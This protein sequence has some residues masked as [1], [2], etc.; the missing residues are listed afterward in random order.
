MDK[1]EGPPSKGAETS[2]QREGRTPSNGRGISLQRGEFHPSV[3]TCLPIVEKLHLVIRWNPVLKLDLD[4]CDTARVRARLELHLLT[5]AIHGSRNDLKHCQQF[6]RT[7]FSE[8]YGFTI[9]T[10]SQLQVCQISTT[11][12]H[13]KKLRRLPELQAVI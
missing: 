9:V 6:V 2:L 12:L 3:C 5:T 7:K 1:R 4:V 8:T 13:C 11:R 10:K